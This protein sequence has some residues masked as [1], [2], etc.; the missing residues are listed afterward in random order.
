MKIDEISSYSCP[1][2]NFRRNPLL[3]GVRAGEAGGIMTL[4]GGL[5]S[6]GRNFVP[7][8]TYAAWNRGTVAVSL[9]D[10]GTGTVSLKGGGNS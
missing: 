7:C 5:G 1:D 6:K 4:F 3:Q 8:R 10:F 2:A 9:D